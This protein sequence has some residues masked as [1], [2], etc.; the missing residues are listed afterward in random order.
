MLE[1]GEEELFCLK[2][3]GVDAAAPR[4]DSDG[5]LK[6]KHLVIQQILDGAARSIGAVKDSADHDGVVRG[7]VVAQHA[8]GVVGAPGEGRAAKQAVEDSKTSSRS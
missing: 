7:V 3:L 6:M 8:A 1:L 5:V 4:F 2:C